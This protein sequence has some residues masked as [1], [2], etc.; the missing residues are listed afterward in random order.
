MLNID[1]KYECQA[2]SRILCKIL[3]LKKQCA[4][5]PPDAMSKRIDTHNNDYSKPNRFIFLCWQHHARVHYKNEKVKTHD[6]ARDL[7]P[8]QAAEWYL[9][10]SEI[11]LED[12]ERMSGHRNLKEIIRKIPIERGIVRTDKRHYFKI[13]NQE[14]DQRQRTRDRKTALKRLKRLKIKNKTCE[15]SEI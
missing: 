11:K 14:Y 13:F 8:T 9:R 12:V 15:I 4:L 1:Q 3:N 10:C 6:Y 7:S 2:N 5:C